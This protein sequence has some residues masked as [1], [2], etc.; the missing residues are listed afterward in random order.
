MWRGGAGE[1]NGEVLAG[2][3]LRESINIQQGGDEWVSFEELVNHA[4]VMAAA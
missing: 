1:E 3:L 4:G 2:T